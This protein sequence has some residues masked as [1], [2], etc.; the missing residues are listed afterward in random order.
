[1]T[2]DPARRPSA[3]LALPGW[4][5]AACVRALLSQHW[6]H[7]RQRLSGRLPMQCKD[8]VSCLLVLVQEISSSE[9]YTTDA[10]DLGRANSPPDLLRRGQLQRTTTT[11]RDH[12]PRCYTMWDGRGCSSR[13]IYG[14]TRE[15]FLQHLSRP[16][17]T[18]RLH[19]HRAEPARLRPRGDHRPLQASTRPTGSNRHGLLKN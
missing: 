5:S 19:V 13:A 7:A 1:M 15:F 16:G 10:R 4:S 2:R 17:C 18:P 11:A 6:D 12:H 8:F 14:E 9:A 3:L